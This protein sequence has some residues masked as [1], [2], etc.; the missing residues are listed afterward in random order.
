MDFTVASKA[1]KAKATHLGFVA[2]QLPSLLKCGSP[3]GFVVWKNCLASLPRMA[4]Q[5]H[6]SATYRICYYTLLGSAR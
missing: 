3:A 1:A 5:G 6:D 2:Q 4:Q